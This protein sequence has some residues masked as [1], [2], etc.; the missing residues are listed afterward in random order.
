MR[1]VATAVGVGSNQGEMEWISGPKVRRRL[2]PTGFRRSPWRQNDWSRLQHYCPRASVSAPGLGR[3][4]GD[5]FYGDD[6]VRKLADE[7]HCGGQPFMPVVKLDLT[8]GSTA[9]SRQAETRPA[10]KPVLPRT[11]D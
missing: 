5:S 8:C 2:E 10:A 7:S 11:V 4:E 9:D 3:L 6:F 1:A